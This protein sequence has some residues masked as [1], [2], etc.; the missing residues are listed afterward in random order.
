MQMTATVP[1]GAVLGLGASPSWD[2][3][4]LCL[5]RWA[6]TR[7]HQPSL[8]T[9]WW[10]G[11]GFLASAPISVAGVVISSKEPRLAG[12]WFVSCLALFVF[13]VMWVLILVMTFA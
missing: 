6:C 13:V 2:C 12:A 11:L 4:V 5:A 7:L 9:A 8:G 10:V 1:M 3:W